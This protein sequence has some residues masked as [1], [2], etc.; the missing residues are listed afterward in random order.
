MSGQQPE[1]SKLDMVQV[2][3][4]LPATP[5]PAFDTRQVFN[6]ERLILRGLKSTDL[7]LYARLRRQ[8]ETMQWTIQGG[9]DRDMASTQDNLGKMLPPNDVNMFNFAICLKEND[10]FIGLGGCHQP[11]GELGWPI[12]GYMFRSEHWGKG[13]ATEFLSTFLR[14]WWSLPRQESEL[15]VDRSTIRNKPGEESCTECII[16]VTRED[17]VASQNVLR[18]CGLDLVKIWS[19]PGVHDETEEV[20]LH[21]FASTKA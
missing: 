13:Y 16:A 18:K 21:A 8:P 6:S 11:L 17:N 2:R 15:Q 1:I 9:P 3:T 4:T 14:A 20:L 5:F 7:E 10:E 19:V 12:I